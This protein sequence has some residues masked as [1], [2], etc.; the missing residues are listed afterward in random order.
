MSDTGHRERIARRWLVN[1]PRA[2]PIV[3]FLLIASIAA[4]S[5]FAIESVEYKRERARLHGVS[6]SIEASLERR[7]ITST[8]YLRAGAAMFTAMDRVEEP[9]FRRFVQAL[10]IDTEYRGRTGVGWAEAVRP[11]DYARRTGG[12]GADGRYPAMDEGRRWIVP[13]AYLEPQKA[14]NRKVIGYDMYSDPV[15]RAA[16]V[17][18]EK[19]MQPSATGK[20]TL[21]LPSNGRRVSGF[22]IFMPVFGGDSTESP[23][24]PGTP[25]SLKGFIYSPFNAQQFLNSVIEP[26]RRGQIAVRLYDGKVAADRLLA[27]TDPEL[28]SGNIISSAIMIANRPMI[29]QVESVLSGSLSQ[30]SMATLIFGMLVASL[31]M[32]VARLLTRQALEDRASLDWLTEQ[33]SIRNSLTRELNHR[34]KNTLANVLSIIALTRRRAQTLDEFATGIDGRIRAL[35]ATHD[36]LTQSEWGTTPISA[37]MEAELAP[38]FQN[39]NNVVAIA[40]PPVQLAP[41]EALSLGLAI[42]ELATN[43]AKYGALG[44]ANGRVSITWTLEE[45]LAH[46]V[47]EES[48]GPLVS[49]NRKRGFGTDLIEKVVAH[50][51]SNPVKLEFAPTGVRCAIK[52]PVRTPSD[53]SLRARRDEARLKSSSGKSGSL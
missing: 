53:F 28:T 25:G 16:L 46:V 5:V 24:T 4:L 26:E 10:S 22:I 6:E 1:Y 15:R 48:G 7:G 9:M 52:V 17:E 29:L 3:I 37:I 49:A 18:A 2:V 27:A 8:T 45:N 11:A 32:I 43:A 47:W 44:D 34:V 30:L 31:L 36:L 20:I 12:S 50:E 41:N 19:T 13:V 42:H 51:L 21:L 35:S 40:G 39:G 14:A 23:G 38:Y 33:N